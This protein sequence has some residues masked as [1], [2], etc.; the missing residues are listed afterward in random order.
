VG[1]TAGLLLGAQVDAE[2]EDA[3]DELGFG[4]AD[5]GVVGEVPLGLLTEALALGPFDGG[6]SPGPYGLGPLP[7]AGHHLVGIEHG[8]QRRPD[9]MGANGTPAGSDLRP[10]LFG[11]VSNYTGPAVKQVCGRTRGRDGVRSVP[12]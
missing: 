3:V 2:G 10:N 7:K 9:R 8:H 1:R 5:H 6:D 12:G 4:V 11:P